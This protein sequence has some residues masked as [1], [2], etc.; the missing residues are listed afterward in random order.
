MLQG[1]PMQFT[2]LAKKMVKIVGFVAGGL[3]LVLFGVYLGYLK[4]GRNNIVQPKENDVTA[5][6]TIELVPFK[7]EDPILNEELMAEYDFTI[8]EIWDEDNGDCIRY[9]S[10]M[11]M[12]AENCEHRDDEIYSYVAGVCINMNKQNGE[13]S[14][15][16][17]ESAKDIAQSGNVRYHQ[18]IADPETENTLS[19]LGISK[20]PA[21]I[22]INRR[23]EIM[24]IVTDMTGKELLVHM[25]E[26]VEDLMELDWEQERVR[27]WKEE[28][29]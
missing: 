15:T 4:Y 14:K 16:K 1:V 28:H 18:Y 13:V 6:K 26:L 17:L 7:E 19:A 2:A 25:D 5:L 3:L 10:E 8:L 29:N 9:I 21:V 24:D 20:Y 11:N 22:F 23:G 27:K 12:F